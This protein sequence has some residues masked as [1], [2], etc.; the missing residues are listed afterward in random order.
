MSLA[1]TGVD[2]QSG[3]QY[4]TIH[5]KVHAH[6]ILTQ[7]NIKQGLLT[8]G[9]K[10]SQAISKELK[11]LHDKGAITPIQ[12]SDMTTEERRKALRYLMFLKEKRYGTKKARGCADG[13]PQRQYTRKEEVS[14][15]TVLLEAMMLSCAIDAKEGR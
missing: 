6:V 15:P 9:E 1:I 8:F 11:Q 13:R 2:A 10:G 12:R 4:L 7:M 14:S 5:P 3:G